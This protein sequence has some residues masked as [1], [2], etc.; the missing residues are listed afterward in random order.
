MSDDPPSSPWTCRWEVGS[1]CCGHRGRPG[2]SPRHSLTGATACRP[3]LPTS[4]CREHRVPR[5]V[6]VPLAGVE[7][8]SRSEMAGPPVG[9]RARRRLLRHA[10]GLK[11]QDAVEHPLLR[12]RQRIPADPLRHRPGP[13]VLAQH[14]HLARPHWQGPTG[15]DVHEGE[16]EA[17]L[18][19]RPAVVLVSLALT[20]AA[21]AGA[22]SAATNTAAGSRQHRLS[23]DR[24]DR[25]G[26]P[27]SVKAGER[28][29]PG[30]AITRPAPGHGC[31][32]AG[33]SPAPTARPGP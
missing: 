9:L 11:S 1:C 6:Q 5:H 10:G 32:T 24:R 22:S 7:L 16:V 30:P 23:K 28:T 13:E 26:K 4:A 33:P 3:D 14:E 17:A 27:S 2:R 29:R 19:G 21:A 15:P 12:G 8:T 25:Q 18:P 31:V 20:L